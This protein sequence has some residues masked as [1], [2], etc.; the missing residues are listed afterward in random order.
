MV[1]N[2]HLLQF[3][4]F[5]RGRSDEAHQTSLMRVNVKLEY[6]SLSPSLSLTHTHTLCGQPYVCMCM[7]MNVCMYA[8]VDVRAY[9]GS[10]G[11]CIMSKLTE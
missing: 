4:S 7:C 9:V 10:D 6:I 1:P 3:D 11:V 5:L 2:I 8:R